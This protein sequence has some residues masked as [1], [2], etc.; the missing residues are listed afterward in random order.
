MLFN[1]VE[2]SRPHF[3]LH[4]S[5]LF[6][7]FFSCLFFLHLFSSVLPL[8]LHADSFS[9]AHF[10]QMSRNCVLLRTLSLLLLLWTEKVRRHLLWQEA[11][12]WTSGTDTG[13]ARPRAQITKKLQTSSCFTPCHCSAI[14]P[15]RRPG[16]CC[17]W[18][19][20]EGCQNDERKGPVVVLR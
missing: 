20:S 14:R 12:S 13:R 5:H 16:C 9:L 4:S 7:C 19:K 2:V 17:P 11:S 10:G 18:R 3:C 8:F 1:R 15:L 6:V